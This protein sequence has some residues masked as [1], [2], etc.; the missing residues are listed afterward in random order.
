M[1]EHQQ[2]P[3]KTSCGPTCIAMIVKRDARS[4]IDMLPSVRSEK[5]KKKRTHDTNIAEVVA[6]LARF[7]YA[8][9]RRL[10][11]DTITDSGEE[12]GLLRVH[13]ARK[14]GTGHRS[15]WHWCLLAEGCVF[16]PL[17]FDDMDASVFFD[18]SKTHKIF[19]YAVTKAS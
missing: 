1:I 18:E 19:F 5:R 9:D 10:K 4:I 11:I 13:H 16:D 8:V 6:L 15:G 2:Q 12:F 3:T 17:M 7:G 14:T